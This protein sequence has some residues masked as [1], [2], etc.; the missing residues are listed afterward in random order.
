MNSRK[1]F[2][3]LSCVYGR[4][5]NAIE[6]VQQEIL[7]YF[8]AHPNAMDTADGIA[9]WW[10]DPLRVNAAVVRVALA[11]LEARG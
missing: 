9:E 3:Q 5:M 6:L 8:R 2:W 4:A 7:T 1:S 11:H 10:L